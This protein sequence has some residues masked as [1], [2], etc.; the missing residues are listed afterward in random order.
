M[1]RLTKLMSQTAQ[2]LFRTSVHHGQF[3][4]TEQDRLLLDLLAIRQ[5]ANTHFLP[6]DA[7]RSS[8]CLDRVDL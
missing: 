5:F 1:D 2:L 8:S 3:R 6:R 4:Q 7:E